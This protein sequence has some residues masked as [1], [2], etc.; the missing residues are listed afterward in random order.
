[1]VR[2]FTARTITTAVLTVATYRRVGE[3]ITIMLETAT[4]ALAEIAQATRAATPEGCYLV[5]AYTLA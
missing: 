3:T 1:M 2:T 4:A 5:G